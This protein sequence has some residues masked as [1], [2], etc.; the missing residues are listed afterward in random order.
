MKVCR[1][2][3]EKAGTAGARRRSPLLSARG[4]GARAAGTSY[5]KAWLSGWALGWAS[6]FCWRSG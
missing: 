4:R 2:P 3:V 1:R 5:V 6:A